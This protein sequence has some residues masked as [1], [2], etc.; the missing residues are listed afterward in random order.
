M[1]AG[2]AQVLRDLG[3]GWL[4]CQDQQGIYYFNQQTQQSSDTPPQQMAVQPLP[5]AQPAAIASVAGQS[6][7]LRELGGGWLQCKDEQGIFFFNQQT[8]QSSDVVPPELAGVA[9]QLQLGGGGQTAALQQP[10]LQPK[11]M[12]AQFQVQQIQAQQEQQ[13]AAQTK[14]KLTLG[15]WI[16][17]ED[18][19][20]EF[21]Y[22]TPSGQS[23]DQPPQELVQLY[24]AQQPSPAPA[25][26]AQQVIQYVQQPMQAQQAYAPQQA[27]ATQQVFT[28]AASYQPQAQAGQQVYYTQYGGQR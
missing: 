13:T 10:Q 7:V 28:S 6:Q 23:F 18:S 24:K 27:Y 9:A 21:Y 15:P 2:Q 3:G 25:A 19:Q 1:A 11:Q 8:Q 16:V 14:Q 12:Q 4:Q 20:G 17:C 26:P 22:H 5:A